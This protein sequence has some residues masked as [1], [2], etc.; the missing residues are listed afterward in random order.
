MKKLA[1]AG[2]SAVLAALPV[3][4]TFAATMTVTDTIQITVGSSCT[5]KEDA[6]NNGVDTKA[7]TYAATVANG[8]ETTFSGT[9]S[10]NHLFHV[11][12]NDPDGWTFSAEPTNLTGWTDNT[13][14]SSNNGSINFVASGSYAAN[15]T[16]GVWTAT[17]TAAGQNVTQPS[18]AGSSN[19]IITATGAQAADFEITSAY[20][21]Y[22]GTQTP[23]G[24]YE[25]TIAYTLAAI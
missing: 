9:H 19:T 25:G 16:A 4:G 7:T 11:T 12:C 22:V 23:A 15:G 24:Y 14:A 6:T 21:A 13:K 8:E 5:I 17:I 2:A 1:I 3:V 20:K 18:A 10:G